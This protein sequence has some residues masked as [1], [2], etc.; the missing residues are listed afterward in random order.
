M[1]SRE[2][3]RQLGEVRPLAAAVRKLG[4]ADAAT[5][6]SGL[7]FVLEGLHL[8]RKLNKDVQSGHTRYTSGGGG[9]DKGGRRGPLD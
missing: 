5:V 4:G 9:A 3:V 1:P 6:A 8:S 2:Y 7:E